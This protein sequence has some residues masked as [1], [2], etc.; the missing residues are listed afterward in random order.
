MDSS[1]SSGFYYGKLV[2]E[3]KLESYDFCMKVY[4]SVYFITVQ[5]LE[6]VVCSPSTITPSEEIVLK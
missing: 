3:T 5:K 6:F 2:N 4:A 1:L